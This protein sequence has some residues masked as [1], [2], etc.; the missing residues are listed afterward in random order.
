[1]LSATDIHHVVGLLYYASAGELA[2]VITLGEKVL[3]TASD[4]RRDVDI[5]IVA[6]GSIAMVA[7][8]V[9]HERRPLFSR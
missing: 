5:V 3:D 8:E 7:A 9:K 6:A 4:T 2:S 1:M